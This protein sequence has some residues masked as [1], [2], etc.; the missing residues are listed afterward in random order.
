L[1]QLHHLFLS[2]ETQLLTKP[3]ALLRLE[4][5]DRSS[6]AAIRAFVEAQA[7]AAGLPAGVVDDLIQAVDEAAANIVIHG[8]GD[9]PGPLEVEFAILRQQKARQIRLTLRDQAPA[10]DP[11]QVQP[12]D[13]SRPFHERKAGGMGVYLIRK[14]IDALD[15]RPLNGGNE[16]TLT[17]TVGDATQI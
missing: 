5:A 13:L 16:L 8:Y 17:K 12:P 14:C 10:F 15:Y 4:R 2:R 9:R 6:L 3:P 11:R 1:L 7:G